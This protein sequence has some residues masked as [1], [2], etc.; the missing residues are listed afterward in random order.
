[1]LTDERK[2]FID[3]QLRLGEKVLC[4]IPEAEDYVIMNDGYLTIDK[5]NYP[6]QSFIPQYLTG[7][8]L[9][10]LR[11]GDRHGDGFYRKK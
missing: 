8:A 2:S 11:L 3:I 4:R 5:V 7:L 6:I 10:N 1:M 9:I